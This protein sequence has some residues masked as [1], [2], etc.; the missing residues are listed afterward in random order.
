MDSPHIWSQSVARNAIRGRERTNNPSPAAA[1]MLGKGRVK[2][3]KRQARK[4]GRRK[5]HR[6]NPTAAEVAS[7]VPI[8]GAGLVTGLVSSLGGRFRKPSEAR[9]SSVSESVVQAANAGNLTAA[10]G[11]I[12]RAAKPMKVAEHAVWQAAAARLSPAIVQQVNANLARIPQA[13]QSGPEKFAAS[14]LGNPVTAA[15]GAAAPASTTLSQ[16]TGLLGQPGTIRAIAS[17]ARPR[18]RRQRYPTYS[19]RYGRQRYSYKPPGS[20]MRIPAGAIP[21]AGTPYSFFQGA[22]GGGSAGTTAAQLGLAAAAGTAAY[23]GTQAIL[24]HFGGRALNAEEGGVAAAL[25][26]RE[27]RYQ[28]AVAH[29]LRGAP[30]SYGV[31]ASVI[32]QIGA[33]MK[34]QLADLGYNAQGVRTRSGVEN[35]LSDYAPEG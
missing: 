28:Y 14:V 22:I 18:S 7:L 34:Q 25:A 1:S 6:G 21:T 10:R 15:A 19:D 24:K 17:V 16:I 20:Q 13:D 4:L 3:A 31:P 8:P 33:G 26:A 5:R 9:A 29:N 23:F 30:P 27:A 12:E 11:L 32:A 35:F 2:A